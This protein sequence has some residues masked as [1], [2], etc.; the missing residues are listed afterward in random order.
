MRTTPPCCVSKCSIPS[1]RA[2]SRRFFGR[3]RDAHFVFV[4][5]EPE[6]MGWWAYLDRRLERLLREAGVSQSKLACIARPASPSPA[7]SFHHD[8]EKDQER[9][10][11]AAFT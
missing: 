9:L 5:E 2:S 6:N 3:W 10:V 1:R 11:K 8:H 4:Q 7:G